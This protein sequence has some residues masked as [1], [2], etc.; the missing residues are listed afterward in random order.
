MQTP[1][2]G[3]RQ[4]PTS[5]PTAHAKS[6]A[7]QISRIGYSVFQLKQMTFKKKRS[8]AVCHH[9]DKILHIVLFHVDMTQ[10]KAVVLSTMSPINRMIFFSYIMGDADFQSHEPPS[11]TPQN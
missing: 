10:R 7:H 2:Y 11:K 8:V 3:N 9:C 4:R 6:I 5:T 1:E